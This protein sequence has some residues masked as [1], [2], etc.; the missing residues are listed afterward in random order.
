MTKAPALSPA[1]ASVSIRELDAGEVAA[2]LDELSAI[3]EEAVALGAS[4]NF[5]AGFSREDGRAYWAAQL[6][7]L[8]DGSRR[9][10]V[11]EAEGLL[12]GTVM[13]TF[14]AQPNA[15][16][17]ADVGKMLV[18][19][20]ARR[21]GVGRRLLD[22]AEEVARAAGR[23]L[24]LLDTETGS[25]AESLYRACG[26]TPFGVVP[27][28]AFRPDGASLGDTTFFYKVLGPHRR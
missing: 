9:L 19:A 2:R 21:L 5:M 4:V 26:W 15:P 27:A 11:A 7:G 13:L 25:A 20:S 22:R 6:P 16:H 10:V 18:A 12:L 8:A 3:L 28:H 17:R 24:L 23:T 14:A 1:P